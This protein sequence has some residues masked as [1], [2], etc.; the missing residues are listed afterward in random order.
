MA[1][2]RLKLLIGNRSST[3]AVAE[4]LDSLAEPRPPQIG[5]KLATINGQIHTVRVFASP[6]HYQQE[7]FWRIAH[8]SP[9]QLQAAEGEDWR[10]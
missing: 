7:S 4:L 5:T 2:D 6:T 8:R 1:S 3:T 9:R 10:C